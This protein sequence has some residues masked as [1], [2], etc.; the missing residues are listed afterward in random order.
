ML[1]AQVQYVPGSK[2]FQSSILLHSHSIS[3]QTMGQRRC[4]HTLQDLA[5][6]KSIGPYLRSVV[7]VDSLLAES[8]LNVALDCCTSRYSRVFDHFCILYTAHA[9]VQSSECTLLERTSATEATLLQVS[10]AMLY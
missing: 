10:Q 9:K 8:K 3:K 2:L 4:I 1:P 6:P 5:E 7:K